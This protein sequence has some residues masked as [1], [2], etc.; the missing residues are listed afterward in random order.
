MGK[1]TSKQGKG[2]TA[3]TSKNSSWKQVDVSPGKKSLVT[4]SRSL[5]TCNTVP[6]AII[7]WSSSV[8]DVAAASEVGSNDGAG[9]APATGQR[10]CSRK[11]SKSKVVGC[12]SL[13]STLRFPPPHF[14]EKGADQVDIT[15]GCIIQKPA[16]FLQQDTSTP[17][18]LL[19]SS[20]PWDCGQAAPKLVQQKWV[21]VRS[22]SPVELDGLNPDPDASDV[23]LGHHLDETD[24]SQPTPCNSHDSSPVP[25]GQ[26]TPDDN[27]V[28]LEA[29]QDELDELDK[30]DSIDFHWRPCKTLRS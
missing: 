14:Q 9:E 16:W 24:Q 10:S 15:T 28:E 30:D 5:S 26:G 7:T 29:S 17:V 13:G 6:K 2:I 20:G 23:S 19:G 4:H 22:L 27:L 11:V 21:Q 1:V 3:L 8:K 25:A 18:H 12:K